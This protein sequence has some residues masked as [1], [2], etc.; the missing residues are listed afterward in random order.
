MDLET[1]ETACGAGIL[2]G[3]AG[4]AIE[5]SL[6]D[7]PLGLDLHRVPF[8]QLGEFAPLFG[9]RIAIA[10]Q[11]AWIQPTANPFLE[12]PR[13]PKAVFG[14]REVDFA[15]ITM[16]RIGPNLLHLAFGVFQ[17][18]PVGPLKHGG[19]VETFA[20]KLD[21]RVQ[22]G[23]HFELQFQNEVPVVLLG[24]EKTIAGVNNSR[25]DDFAVFHRVNSL[26]AALDPAVQVFAVKKLDRILFGD[27]SRT[28]QQG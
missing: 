23:I 16:H 13:R 27:A 22:S 26:A 18:L 28:E 15:L 20:A 24:A 19:L 7:G 14:C 8:V 4:L 10:T 3:G 9:E 2:D 17:R 12:D 5:P 6:D 1:Y 11:G 21:A 25:A